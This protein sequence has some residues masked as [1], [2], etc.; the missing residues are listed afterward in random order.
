M[1]TIIFA[2]LFSVQ[3]LAFCQSLNFF[4]VTQAVSSQTGF[5]DAADNV[6]SDTWS[7]AFNLGVSGTTSG[8]SNLPNPGNG[9]SGSGSFFADH[10]FGLTSWAL[11]GSATGAIDAGLGAA[12]GNFFP[13]IGNT[14]ILSAGLWF[15]V[16]EPFTLTLT[17]EVFE[18][19]IGND[20][21]MASPFSN[22]GAIRL[23]AEILDGNLVNQDLIE[24]TTNLG[25][26][27]GTYTASFN[28]GVFRLSVLA[29]AV[30]SS[31]VPE[32]FGT[33]FS[34]YDAQLSIQPIPE[35]G[36]ALLLVSAAV[37]PLLRRRRGSAGLRSMQRNGGGGRG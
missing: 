34:S 25:S 11:S 19:F 7:G 32:A 14:T 37:Y 9:A 23:F 26:S 13:S 6:Q 31:N 15:A 12:P 28:S 30:L 24:W 1:K 36:S 20:P 33:Q 18:S 10:Q 21:T 27:G 16:N 5:R 8:G 35:P 2:V 4:D 3:P 29:N 17:G 22:A